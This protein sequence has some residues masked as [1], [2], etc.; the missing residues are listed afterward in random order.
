MP[1]KPIRAVME[2][3]TMPLIADWVLA[4]THKLMWAIMLVLNM[5]N[6]FLMFV[7]ITLRA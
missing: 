7:L 2:V 3:K 4:L 6:L 5:E 1:S